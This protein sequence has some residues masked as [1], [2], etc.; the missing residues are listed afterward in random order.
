VEQ[1]Y[2][3]L[4]GSTWFALSGP[5]NLP[6]EI[7]ERLN[8][9]VVKILHASDLQARFAREAIDTKSLDAD[10]FTAYFKA[11]AVHWT[12]LARSVAE[13]AKAGGAR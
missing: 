11:E 12:P 2:A 10:A 6:R 13:Q 7:V 4:I 3:G 1:G 9:E 8:T 5:A